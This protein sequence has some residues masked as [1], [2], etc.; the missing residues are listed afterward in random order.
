MSEDLI[1]QHRRKLAPA[2]A[3]DFVFFFSVE[4]VTY[5]ESMRWEQVSRR[6]E[7]QGDTNRFLEPLSF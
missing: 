5:I 2:F 4:L 3:R 1:H 7:K 6:K